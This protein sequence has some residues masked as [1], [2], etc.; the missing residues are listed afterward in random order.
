[1]SNG[2]PQ[3][4]L[5]DVIALASD[6]N[7][8]D[9]E[10]QYPNFGIFSLGRG[11]FPKPP[12]SGMVSSAT[13]LYRAHQGQFIYSRLFA[14]EGAYGVVSP[15]FDGCFVSNEYPMFDCDRSRI[16][17]EFLG[18]YFKW[19][20]VW[21]DVA[22]LSS[23]MGDRRR[24][25]QPDQFLTHC[26]R[27]PTLS[28]QQRIV[29]KVQDLAAEIEEAASVRRKSKNAASSLTASAMNDIWAD[30]KGWSEESVSALVTT[31]CGQVMSS[32]TV[33]NTASGR[34]PSETPRRINYRVVSGSRCCVSVPRTSSGPTGSST[35]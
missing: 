21:Q 27:L 16:I 29:S 3:V 11:L 9:A 31:V 32:S 34:N 19:P 12:I 35:G 15:E 23:G 2:W 7:S 26:I 28:E 30:T 8:V 22:R 4:P 13:T 10:Q 5:G 20:S 18:L 25:V 24:R 1:V 6:P 14:F 33:R 17:P